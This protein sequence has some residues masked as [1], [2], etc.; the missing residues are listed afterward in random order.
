MIAIQIGRAVMG[1]TYLV[2]FARPQATP[3]FRKRFWWGTAVL[4]GIALT[5]LMPL[6]TNHEPWVRY[7]SLFQCIF[8]AGVV[9]V[10]WL[11]YWLYMPRDVNAGNAV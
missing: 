6:R 11:R 4:L 9:G 8:N 7:A 1:I 2:L 3:E 10:L 5:G